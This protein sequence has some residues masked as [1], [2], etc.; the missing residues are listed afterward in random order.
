[1]KARVAK[2]LRILLRFV[3]GPVF[4]AEAM[5][6]SG[7]L[8]AFLWQKILRVN[9]H[10][11]WPVHPTTHVKAPENI[12]RGTRFPG[13]SAGC[14]LDG[15]N[16]IQFGVNVWVGPYVSLISMNHDILDYSAYE[17]AKPICIGDNCWLGAR[18]VILPAVS[19]GPAH[20]GGRG[21]GGDPF[22]S[23]R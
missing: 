23:G 7:C 10:V 16:G 20:R 4:G 2:I 9:A 17:A 11:P 18:A 22:V 1:V 21:G 3:F 6:I 15:R 5:G 13:L 19:L 12:S 14:H 8:K